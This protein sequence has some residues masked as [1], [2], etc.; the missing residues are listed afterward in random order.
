MTD[1]Q[2]D[3]CLDEC[4]KR[5]ERVRSVLHDRSLDRAIFVSHENV[6]YLTGFRPHRLMQ[7][8]VM[9][10]A[11]E[12]VLAAPNSDPERA[13]A[14][15]V[16]T[17]E[18][19]WCATLR[20]EQAEQSLRVLADSVGKA[21]PSRTGVEFSHCGPHV[22]TLLDDEGSPVDI[23]ADLWKLRRRKAPDELAMI[24]RAVDCT[25]AMYARAREIIE[26]GITELEVFNQLHAAAVVTAGE[27]LTAIGNDY[28]CNSPGGPPRTRAAQD[29]E[30][31]ILDLGPAYRGYYAD[32]C[33][34]I[35]VNRRPTD[36]QQQAAEAIVAV[37]DMVE[38][39][40]RPGVSAKEV[41]LTAKSMLDSFEPDAFFHH[42]GHGFG[43]FPHEAPH[44]N[45]NWD[46]VFEEGDTFTAE[47]GLYT[48]E[49]K[50]GI[51]LEQNYVVTADGVDRLTNFTLDL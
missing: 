20:Q 8:A 22:R 40:V 3:L 7:A 16:A 4:R 19:Q 47:P 26:S 21:A 32:N 43:L 14:D 12:A 11:S 49:L 2:P 5:Q 44:L 30:L 36:R 10:D 42:L 39:T 6:Q 28:Q 9:I 18:A 45:P 37:L 34:T 50:A 35:A 46:D 31:F 27:Q 24:R 33:R 17:F 1:S 38:Q 29:G 51:R 48:E 25:E 41:Y 15:R 23:D 13:A